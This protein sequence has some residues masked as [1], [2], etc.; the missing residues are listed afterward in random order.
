MVIWKIGVLS[1]EATSLSLH[2]SNVLLP[3]EAEM[4]IYNKAGTMYSGP[5]TS[6][7]IF[8]GIYT[9]DAIYGEEV[10]LEVILP[11]ES[12]ETFDLQID[13]VIHGFDNVV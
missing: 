7:H 3:P 5:V 1:N 2:L 4:Y 9:T 10:V 6:Q 12:Y 11:A 13:A 8:N